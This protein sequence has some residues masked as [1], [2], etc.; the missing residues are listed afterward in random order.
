MDTKDQAILGIYET[1][2]APERWPVVLDQLVDAMEARAANLFLGNSI[3]AELQTAWLSGVLADSFD[4]P[5]NLPLIEGEASL[6]AA[7]PA[8]CK[9]REFV[10]EYQIIEDYQRAGYPRI[11]V[12][13]VRHR[14]RKGY[15]L[16]QRFSAPLNNDRQHFDFL[17]FHFG[18]RYRYG[19]P[20]P[21][22][23]KL[24]N[25]LLPHLSKALEINRPFNLLHHRYRAVLEVLDRLRLGVV[26]MGENRQ[27]WLTNRSADTILDRRDGLHLDSRG[28][29]RANG[30]DNCKTLSA[31][32]KTILAPGP[33]RA[34]TARFRLSRPSSKEDYVVDASVIPGS[35]LATMPRTGGVLML[36]VDPDEHECANLRGFD[37]LF[38]LTVT[39]LEVCKL[40]V[41]GHSNQEIADIRNV[42]LETILTHVKS[43][44]SKTNVHRRGE[45]IHLAHK[46]NIPV[47]DD[48][49]QSDEP[50]DSQDQALP[51]THKPDKPGSR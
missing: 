44:F 16:Y 12:D 51:A 6:Y 18:K 47:R 1:V 48:E 4:V 15:G 39:E 3:H 32:I 42:G 23:L 31:S 22:T 34:K 28:F 8:L 26:I 25:S 36:V 17:T 10:S 33:D 19:A 21:G 30:Q 29:I 40:V 38:D 49:P 11:P 9:R 14:L 50:Q 20:V 24:G 13:Q 27:R 46:V 41:R 35:P 5:E 37:V 2:T 45:L 43:L 7:M